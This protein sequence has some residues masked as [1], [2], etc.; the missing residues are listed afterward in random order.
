MTDEIAKNK[1]RAPYQSTLRA[2]HKQQTAL[3]ILQSVAA[4]IRKADL[5][6]VSIAEVARVADVTE[7]TVYRHYETRDDL[8]RA[9]IKWHLEQ[10]L[11]GQKVVLV[12]TIDALFAW[13]GRRCKNWEED[14]KIITETYLSP[15]GRELRRPLYELARNNNDRLLVQEIP[16]L[17]EATRRDLAATILTLMSTE[18]FVFLRQNLGYSPAEI[19]RCTMSAIRTMIEGA[20]LKA[21]ALDKPHVVD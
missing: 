7:R 8:I 18:N 12:Q 15:L 16:G 10:S 5:A 3:L 19:Y 4:I 11:G 9:F 20:R 1:E 17:D 13:F 21:S 2:R 6:S 14:Y